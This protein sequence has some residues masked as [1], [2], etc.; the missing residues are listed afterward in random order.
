MYPFFET[1]RYHDAQAEGL[2]FH[3]QRVERAYQ[4][5]GKICKLNL[6]EIIFNE[7]SEASHLTN[8]GV[9]KCKLSYDLDGNYS[10]LFEPYSVRKIA[11]FTLVEIGTNKYDH[12]FSDRTWI[13][14][15]V[16]LAKTDDVIFMEKGL[17][18]D[19]SYTNIVLYDGNKWV[20]PKSPLLLGTKR[21]SLLDTHQIIE[22]DIFDTQ[23]KNFKKLKFINAMMHWDESPC[24][25]L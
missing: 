20:T 19:A 8:R 14:N 15:A 1:I 25:D 13:N 21:A 22:Q 2:F 17:I 24:I 9:Y 6:E 4:F 23:L 3:Q 12:K 11:S 5:K 16:A 7:I 10:I 18:K